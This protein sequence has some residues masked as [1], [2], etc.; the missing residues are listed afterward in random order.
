[1][2]N[3]LLERIYASPPR[4]VATG[5]RTIWRAL[6]WRLRMARSASKSSFSPALR[7]VFVLELILEH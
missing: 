3:I 2:T 5:L 4:Q 7:Q 6:P 1:V